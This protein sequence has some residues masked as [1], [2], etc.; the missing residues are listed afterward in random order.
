MAGDSPAARRGRSYDVACR[1]GGAVGSRARRHDRMR[2][3][4]RRA[5][6]L[7]CRLTS[8]QPPDPA[9]SSVPPP[10]ATPAAA[11]RDDGAAAAVSVVSVSVV[12]AVVDL[13]RCLGFCGSLGL[14]PNASR[15][16]LAGLRRR[17]VRPG[18]RHRARRGCQRSHPVLPAGASRG[19]SMD[20]AVT[21][22]A[23][24]HSTRTRCQ[25]R[26]RRRG[27]GRPGR[28]RTTCRLPAR[29]RRRHALVRRLVAAPGPGTRPRHPAPARVTR[30]ASRRHDRDEECGGKHQFRRWRVSVGWDGCWHAAGRGSRVPPRQVTTPAAAAAG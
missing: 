9:H 22:P 13:D 29:P 17:G 30:H 5:A 23:G 27:E 14:G 4:G 2:R 11:I 18:H 16:S 21:A 15:G 12:V 20:V 25:L 1:R 10:R 3:A 7:G 24:G 28:K 19:E 6:G 26:S 8:C